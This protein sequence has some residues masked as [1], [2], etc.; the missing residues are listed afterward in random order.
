[1]KKIVLLL[2]LFSM[3]FILLFVFA[4]CDT[5]AE[6]E[7]SNNIKSGTNSTTTTINLA[8]VIYVS[9][10]GLDTNSGEITSPVKT[11][12]KAV[13]MVTTEK[14]VIFVESGTYEGV[15]N[16]DTTIPLL[17]KGG[18]DPIFSTQNLNNK[19]VLKGAADEPLVINNYPAG[20][21][22]IATIANSKLTI[23]GLDIYGVRY[24]H[25][26]AEDSATSF[27]AIYSE[28]DLTLD[29]CEITGITEG[30][31]GDSCGIYFVGE[32]TSVDILNSVIY[33]ANGNANIGNSHG[34]YG[35]G[36]ETIIC[37]IK[38]STIYGLSG[39][40][41]TDYANYGLFFCYGVLTVS[42]STIYGSAGSAIT[43]SSYG[44]MSSNAT[45]NICDDTKIYG[46]SEN[47]DTVYTYMYV[48]GVYGGGSGSVINVYSGT[49]IYG[50]AGN[51]VII[52]H[53]LNVAGIHNDNDGI[54]NIYGGTIYGAADNAKISLPTYG[55]DSRG[56]LN[57]SGAN[58]IIYGAAGNV[59]TS[60]DVF[61][62][63]IS[64]ENA[65][66]TISDATIYGTADEVSSQTG[67][68]ISGGNAN[69]SISNSTIY[70]VKGNSTGD[71]Y[72][73]V[74][75]QYNIINS[76]IYGLFGDNASASNVVGVSGESTIS[77]STI[78]GAA[79]SGTVYSVKGV[80][81]NV[82]IS[83]ST[84]YGAKDNIVI[85]DYG[86]VYGIYSAN[87]ISNSTV[88]TITDN[89]SIAGNVYGVY[90]SDTIS[91]STIYGANGDS[92]VNSVFNDYDGQFYDGF[93]YGVYSCYDQ[94]AINNGSK[95][96]GAT[97]NATIASGVYGLCLYESSSS[98]NLSNCEIYGEKDL[99]AALPPILKS[100]DFEGSATKAQ[101]TWNNPAGI[102]KDRFTDSTNLWNNLP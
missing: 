41:K 79:G 82:D 20:A 32:N 45:I 2:S 14:N 23:N 80:G 84:I 69:S 67:C 10:S 99:I 59:I 9:T 52:G 68:G 49:E 28:G 55:I 93:V 43:S 94:T 51:A 97:G 98:T 35:G 60:Y 11:I 71:A 95:I 74:Y 63:N 73:I 96:Y 62:I 102:I 1:M 54:A 89:V 70:G 53:G 81:E 37:N 100:I 5:A 8:S 39:N 61:G 76:A 15:V 29:N 36:N 64:G 48:Y 44:I 7:K 34:I 40:A 16:V 92:I 13:G 4:G 21:G 58:T 18:Y 72:G 65:L 19:S 3:V 25:Y 85:T 78:Y 50:A 27:A 46:A 56:A 38:N 86:Y 77:N 101:I 75:G 66:V 22:R 24:N 42:N 88:Y 83:N 47:V 12:S 33:G 31:A 6:P 87:N 91:N 17:I 57:I 30:V 26:V 90:H